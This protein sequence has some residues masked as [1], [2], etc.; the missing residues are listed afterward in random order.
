MT[1]S[2]ERLDNGPHDFPNI[3]IYVDDIPE[4]IFQVL[5]NEC[6][7]NERKIK[8]GEPVEY[9]TTGISAP[10]SPKHILVNES[11]DCLTAFVSTVV[12]KYNNAYPSYINSIRV[13]NRNLPFSYGRPWMNFQSKGEFI[14]VHHHTGI[15]AYA[16][17]VKIP[18]D[19]EDEYVSIENDPNRTWA[20]TTS[21]Q[22]QYVDI[23]GRMRDKLLPSIKQTEGK[24]VMFPASLSHCVYPFYSSN[25]FR[26]SVSGN[27]LLDV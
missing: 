5:Q 15:L 6:F 11:R 1:I 8:A 24:I 3:G 10:G 18:F 26:I 4:G 17:W 21:F 23:L 25:D 19:Y 22:F 12:E 7:E 2:P 13:L 16:I 27:V 9:L 14:P 20:T